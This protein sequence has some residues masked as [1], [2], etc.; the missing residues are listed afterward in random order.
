M[1]LSLVPSKGLS[2][3]PILVMNCDEGVNNTIYGDKLVE[4]YQMSHL[5]VT[6][7]P[8]NAN[9]ELKTTLKDS[10][11]IAAVYIEEGFSKNLTNPYAYVGDIT[12]VLDDSKLLFNYLV[13]LENIKVLLSFYSE[14]LLD[15]EG[16]YKAIV[17]D[18]PHI[19]NV[20]SI[21][22]EL[23]GGTSNEK[24]FFGIKLRS[25]VTNLA[26][27]AAF[28]FANMLFHIE[29]QTIYGINEKA[30]KSL[31][32][33]FYPEILVFVLLVYGLFL[34][35][36]IMSKEGDFKTME[37]YIL[38]RISPLRFYIAK[39]MIVILVMLVQ[40]TLLHYLFNHYTTLGLDYNFIFYS[41]VVVASFIQLGLFCGI[42]GGTSIS[43]IKIALVVLLI[44]L[45]GSTLF[46]PDFMF[47]GPVESVALLMPTT[48][49]SHLFNFVMI[50]HQDVT[51]PLQSLMSINL[52]LFIVNIVLLK[53][54]W[55]SHL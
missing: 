43:S 9:N 18:N 3:I 54:Q 2:D 38:A 7:L 48:H 1:L 20:V 37:R 25:F 22:N 34:G 11:A 16:V 51:I 32:T 14:L 29:T 23:L 45:I 50:T 30:D 36:V 27:E 42:A 55:R 24:S 19:N 35:T 15:S 28:G 47:S 49:A 10:K 52:V 13:G 46:F 5:E 26:P 41:L 4:K 21:L 44:N 53:I 8:C 17:Q 12:L 31:L 39:F 6:S 40:L 33:F